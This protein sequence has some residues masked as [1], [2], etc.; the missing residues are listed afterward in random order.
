LSAIKS[1][2]RTDVERAR[3]NKPDALGRPSS[4][5]PG[6]TVES[7]HEHEMISR[8]AKGYSF[9]ELSGAG[10]PLRVASRW[11]VPVDIR[12]RSVLGANITALK[13]W[14][15]T[16][17]PRKKQSEARK[18]EKEIVKVAEEAAAEVEKEVKA[19]EKA[20]VKAEKK[21]KRA[22]TAAKKEEKKIAKKAGKPRK[23]RAVKKATK[24]KA[25]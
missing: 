21:V 17:K 11:G 13:A 8:D 19:V 16:A 15:G 3:L 14:F 5:I 7:R 4:P 12:R 2:G 9:G 18:V 25:N 1:E 23:K 20:V 10:V 24:K 22:G 6:P